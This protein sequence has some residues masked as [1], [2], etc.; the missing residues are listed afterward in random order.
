MGPSQSQEK[1]RIVVGVDGSAMSVAALRWA[2]RIAPALDATITAVAAWHFPV[3]TGFGWS[4]PSGW[5]PEAG[6]REVLKEALSA[7]FGDKPPQGLTQ[8]TVMGHAAYVLI[9]ESRSARMLVVGSRGHGGF[10]GL[11]LGSVSSACAEHAQCPVMVV[12]GADPQD[13]APS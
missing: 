13:G 10:A 5:D 1:P 4:T 11:L 12:H 6:A 2:A 9:E 3:D 8:R 7:A